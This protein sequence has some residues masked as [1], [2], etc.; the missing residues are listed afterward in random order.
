[1]SRGLALGVAAL[2]AAC[3]APPPADYVVIESREKAFTV[4]QPAPGMSLE[5]LQ[6]LV[7][8]HDAPGTA[9]IVAWADLPAAV[10]EEAAKV[11][12]RDDFPGQPVIPGILCLLRKAP[13][14]WGITWNG[15][16]ALTRNDYDDARRTYA[17][18]APPAAHS[19]VDPRGHL[20]AFGCP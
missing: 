20:P 14:P 4:F 1:V 8:G 15:G 17:T 10:R 2:L 13:A 3:A 12:L 11:M 5:R 16:I 19:P 9:R 18:K 7:A 6:R